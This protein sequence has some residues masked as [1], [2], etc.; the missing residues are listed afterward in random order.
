MP[1]PPLI[2]TYPT[3]RVRLGRRVWCR[4]RRRWCRIT[5]YTDAPIPWPRCQPTRH[6]GGSGL[7]VS[8]TL[9]RAIRTESAAALKHW[10]GVSQTC[11]N[12]WRRWAGVEGHD[13]TAGTRREVKAAADTAAEVTR[14]AN[15]SEEA[16]EVRATNAK[17]L[18]LIEYARAARWPDGWTAEMDA[19]LGTVPDKVLAKQLGTSRSAVRSRRAKLGIPPA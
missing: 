8:G 16:C 10:F 11:A 2:G 17:R 1:P 15:L 5:S 13:T 7:Y 4:Y 18:K 19:L 14:G 6:P 12:A 9:E 3:P